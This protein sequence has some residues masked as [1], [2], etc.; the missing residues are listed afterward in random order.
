MS[1]Y[2]DGLIDPGY[3]HIHDV[4]FCLNQGKETQLDVFEN[5]ALH[6][7]RRTPHDD[8]AHWAYFRPSLR[9]NTPV[10]TDKVDVKDKKQSK[11][12]KKRKQARSARKKNRSR[13]K[14]KR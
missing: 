8:V 13:K 2:D 7:L 10:V 14:K 9:L 6:D 1:S 3:I 5:H 12:K 4:E 11:A